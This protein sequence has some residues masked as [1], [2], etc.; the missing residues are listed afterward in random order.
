MPDACIL[1]SYTLLTPGHRQE[2]RANKLHVG[3][4]VYEITT[5]MRHAPRNISTMTTRLG[6]LSSLAHVLLDKNPNTSRS[7]FPRSP[8]TRSIK[9]VAISQGPERGCTLV[10]KEKSCSLDLWRVAVPGTS[11]TPL[12]KGHLESPSPESSLVVSPGFCRMGRSA[13]H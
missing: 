12:W 6:N 4:L 1:C 5:R 9:N 11:V 8:S 2:K 7:N 3:L 10:H 13:D